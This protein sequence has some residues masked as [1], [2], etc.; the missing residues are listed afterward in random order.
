MLHSKELKLLRLL[1]LLVFD[2]PNHGLDIPAAAKN[3]LVVAARFQL[4]VTFPLM[5]N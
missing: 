4:P 2:R 1:K 3:P 5:A